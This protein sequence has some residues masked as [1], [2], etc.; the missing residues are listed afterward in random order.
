MLDPLKIRDIV[1]DMVGRL[2]KDPGFPALQDV[3]ILD[4]LGK[5]RCERLAAALEEMSPTM[6]SRLFS[7]GNSSSWWMESFHGAKA[8]VDYETLRALQKLNKVKRPPDELEW[9]K[10]LIQ[11]WR[12]EDKLGAFLKEIGEKRSMSILSAFPKSISVPVAKKTFPGS[13]GVLL[14][15]SFSADRLSEIDIIE[16][17]QRSTKHVPP[18]D[19]AVLGSYR[20]EQDLISYLGHAAP[21]EER[22][23]YE[24]LPEN[25]RIFTLRPPFY[26]LF[27]QSRDVVARIAQELDVLDIAMVLHGLSNEFRM[28]LLETLSEKR[29]FMVAEQL[30]RFERGAPD[31]TVV[32]RLREDIGRQIEKVKAELLSQGQQSPMAASGDDSS[33]EDMAGLDEGADADAGDERNAA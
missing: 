5:T 10:L 8:Q 2:E 1:I 7:M 6:R 3:L 25:S 4:E 24:A 20:Q 27:S 13:W 15:P 16:L 14:S 32:A 23:I 19:E 33:T 22:E 18:R 29:G 28:K 21:E 9:N 26:R 31:I 30:K 17:F 11:V 12:L